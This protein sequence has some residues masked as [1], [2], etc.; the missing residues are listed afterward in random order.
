MPRTVSVGNAAS[1]RRLRLTGLLGKR[2]FTPRGIEARVDIF[3]DDERV[4]SLPVDDDPIEL[5]I[6]LPAGG[7]TLRPQAIR[8]AGT[9]SCGSAPAGHLA[10]GNSALS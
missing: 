3:V 10:W 7:K 1:L 4:G 9:C 8:T 2:A 5:D 6:P